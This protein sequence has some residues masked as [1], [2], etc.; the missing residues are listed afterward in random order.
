LEFALGDLVDSLVL[1]IAKR[2]LVRVANSSPQWAQSQ[3]SS[4]TPKRTSISLLFR[5]PDHHGNFLNIIKIQHQHYN[6][7]ITTSTSNGPYFS[8]PPLESA[9]LSPNTHCVEWWDWLHCWRCR[10]LLSFGDYVLISF[11][12]NTTLLLQRRLGPLITTVSSFVPE[13]YLTLQHLR[14]VMIAQSTSV[15]YL[16][17]TSHLSFQ[18]H[19]LP[20]CRNDNTWNLECMRLGRN[21]TH[22]R[23]CMGLLCFV[24]WRV[25]DVEIWVTYGRGEDWAKRVDFILSTSTML[26]MINNSPQQCRTMRSSVWVFPSIIASSPWWTCLFPPRVV[27]CLFQEAVEHPNREC[28]LVETDHDQ[29]PANGN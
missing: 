27:K 7:N 19:P 2:V 8:R 9:S 10:R 13:W 1:I 17:S 5:T 29:H 4:N 21:A 28:R 26:E 23:L 15:T 25:E 6:V 24:L 22:V 12:A 18:R 11:S 16:S 20:K 14:Q 3:A